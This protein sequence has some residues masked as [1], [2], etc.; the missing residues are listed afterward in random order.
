MAV[1]TSGGRFLTMWRLIET[2]YRPLDW[3]INFLATNPVVRTKRF[4]IPA[5]AKSVR[6][7]IRLLRYWFGYQLLRQEAARADRPLDV[8][9]IGVH[10]GQFREFV[11]SAPARPQFRKWTAVDA[12]MLTEKLRKA[13]YD[14]F[15]EANLD[16]IGI[17]LQVDKRLSVDVIRG[18]RS[19]DSSGYGIAVRPVNKAELALDRRPVVPADARQLE[20]P[21]GFDLLDH[22][23]ERVHVC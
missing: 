14:D 19:H 7:P 16:R 3:D 18:F 8:A 23:T 20:P 9:E 4:G 21:I 13:G 1:L 22:P 10:T 12:V 11:A 5:E 17:T 15:V 2:T 6:Y